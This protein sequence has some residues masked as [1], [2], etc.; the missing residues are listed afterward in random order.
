MQKTLSTD[1][2][3]PRPLRRPILAST[4]GAANAIATELASFPLAAKDLLLVLFLLLLLP[5]ALFSAAY[6]RNGE[7]GFVGGEVV[8]RNCV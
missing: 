8:Y 3:T 6:C 4:A 2:Q 5:C 1:S 7:V